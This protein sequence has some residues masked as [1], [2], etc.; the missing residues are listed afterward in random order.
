MAKKPANRKFRYRRPFLY[1]YQLTA[2]F[3]NDRIGCIEASTKSGKTHTALLWLFEMALLLGGPGR[4]FWWLAPVYGQARIGYERLVAWLN[5]GSFRGYFTTK[6]QSGCPTIILA[7]GSTIWF[8]S[9][10]N[11]D[12]L[13]GEDVHAVV[14][15]EASRVRR[16]SW[17]ATRS[18]VTKTRGPMRLIGNVHGKKN[19]FYSMARQ[20]ESGEPGMRY[21]KITAYDAIRVGLLHSDEIREAKRDLPEAVFN[22][23]YL[24]IATDDGSNPF[25]LDH[26]RRQILRDEH[27][28]ETTRPYDSEAVAFGCDLAKYHDWCVTLGLDEK[29]RTCHFDRW[30]MLSAPA[31]RERILGNVG[32][33]STLVDATSLGGDF[34]LDDLQAAREDVFDGYVFTSASKQYLIEALVLAVQQSE[35]WYPRGVITS[36][37]ENFTYSHTRAGGV[38]YEAIEGAHDDGVIGLALANLHRKKHRGAETWRFL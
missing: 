28:N 33:T 25:G 21:S 19:W 37:L 4:H 14:I 35:V 1:L 31:M 3:H 22:E 18:V 16:E 17:W 38:R 5:A 23:L 24:A 2:L 8:R 20:A 10:A 7:N 27:G 15:D 34:T 29:G 6:T 26:I 30:Q 36:E 32:D 12:N 13:F 11:P 9:G